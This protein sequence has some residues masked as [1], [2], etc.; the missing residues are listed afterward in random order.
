MKKVIIMAFLVCLTTLSAAAQQDVSILTEAAVDSTLVGRDIFSLV[1]Q[2]APSEGKITIEQP[3]SMVS[4]MNIHKKRNA[5][6]HING[7]RVRIFFDNSRSARAVS[8]QVAS[9][10][11][12]LYPSVGVYRG[13]ENPYFKVTVGNFRTKADATKFLNSIKGQ[14]PSGFIV[15][16]TINYPSF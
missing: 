8:A 14:F 13:Y 1:S 2:S 7:Y 15:R 16:E 4:A 9:Q 5:T 11:S 3:S 6:K 10:F 12:A